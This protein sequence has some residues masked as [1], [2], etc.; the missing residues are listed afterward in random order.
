MRGNF[1]TLSVRLTSVYFS[2]MIFYLFIF[3]FFLFSVAIPCFSF[4]CT[5]RSFII[6][7]TAHCPWQ[8][9]PINI[10]IAD[11][12]TYGYIILLYYVI[13]LYT[14]RYKIIY[15]FIR[16]TRSMCVHV[17]DVFIPE[18]IEI[19]S[20]RHRNNCHFSLRCVKWLPPFGSRPLGGSENK[21]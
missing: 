16:N 21:T 1:L 11:H 7:R 19:S 15:Y 12:C 6:I 5:L 18:K 8:H 4:P 14:L 20:G 13:L 2:Y 17:A 10:I 9:Y 3:F